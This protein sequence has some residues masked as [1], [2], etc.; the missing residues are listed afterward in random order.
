MLKTTPA[1]P[2]GVTVGTNATILMIKLAS[3]HLTHKM[4]HTIPP[5]LVF[6]SQFHAGNKPL[7]QIVPTMN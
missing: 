2:I 7:F 5:S 6:D 4:F 3:E 1:T